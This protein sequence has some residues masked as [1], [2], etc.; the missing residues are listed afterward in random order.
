MLEESF[1]T[2]IPT[3]AYLRTSHTPI[4]KSG[5]HGLQSQIRKSPVEEAPFNGKVGN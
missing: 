3:F 1:S 4:G 2:L 5:S